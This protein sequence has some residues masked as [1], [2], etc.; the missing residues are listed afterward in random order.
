M[1]TKLDKEILDAMSKDPAN[2]KGPFYFNPKD[3]RL[4]VPRQHP[5]MGWT[6]NFAH[7][8]VYIF[9][10]V[11]ILIVLAFKYLIK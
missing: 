5:W 11:I 3:Y 2:R 10:L 4:I 1:K 6:L 9:L 7:M 8:N